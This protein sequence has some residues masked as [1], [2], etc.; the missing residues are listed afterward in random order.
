MT[1]D[2][3]VQRL[4]TTARYL[5]WQRNPPD[6]VDEQVPN[7]TIKLIGP[8]R[9]PI[10][11]APL[12]TIPGSYRITGSFYDNN[13]GTYSLMITRVN[14]GIIG[15]AIRSGTAYR[16]YI[17]HSR[18]GTVDILGIDKNTQNQRITLQGDPKRPIYSF[19]PGTVIYGFMG[20]DHLSAAGSHFWYHQNLEGILG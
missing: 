19:G 11:R 17:R 6:Y 4:S 7:N 5:D 13:S 18:Q 12:G 10:A 15:T 20:G 1:E 3:K 8:I 9:R 2:N 16:W 14:V